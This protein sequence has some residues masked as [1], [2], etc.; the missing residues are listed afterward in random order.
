[1]SA[2]ADRVV[3]GR[4]VGVYGVKGWIRIE[5]HTRP[6]EAIF[7][8]SPWRLETE[9]GSR[10]GRVVT[11]RIQGPGLVAQIDGIQDRDQAR[12]LIGAQIVIARE[13]LPPAGPGEVY[14]TDL[15]GCRVVNREGIE[16]GTV[17]H[18]FETGANDVLVVVGER[19]RLIPYIDSV[20]ESVDL[21]QGIVRVDWDEDF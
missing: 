4:V 7:E 21:A 13:Q 15:E 14:W 1:M 8:Y 12:T 5:S 3:V 17:S 16:L 9:Q 18:L 20:V 2:A 19:E 10:E 6:R 11:G